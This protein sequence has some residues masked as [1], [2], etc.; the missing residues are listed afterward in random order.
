MARP[1]KK[2]VDYSTD[3]ATLNRIASAVREDERI[4]EDRHSIV[5]SL[6]KAIRLLLAF[7]ASQIGEGEWPAE[8][9]REEKEEKSGEESAKE[10][11]VKEDGEEE[12][13]GPTAA[14]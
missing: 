1:V 10:D 8:G 7:N 3:V 13:S 14:E 11:S 9:G 5:G 2:R 6:H 4:G 12:A